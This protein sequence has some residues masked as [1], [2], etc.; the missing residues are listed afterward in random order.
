MKKIL[1]VED[2]PDLAKLMQMRLAS[3]GYETCVAPDALVAVEAAHRF[4]P[5]LILLDL[6]LPAGG[7]LG[8]LNGLKASIY[9]ASIPVLAVT[10]IPR[11]TFADEKLLL[12]KIDQIGLAGYLQ[13][14]F[15]PKALL[16]EIERLLS[17]SERRGPSGN[18]T[19]E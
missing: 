11:N 16:S 15:D 14:P 19:K 4:G 9:T 12:D 17:G 5:N 8:V 10:A 18:E 13:K 2:E 7:G 3:A 6:M 1:I